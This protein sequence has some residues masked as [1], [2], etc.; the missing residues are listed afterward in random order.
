MV[1][2]Y[3]DIEVARFGHRSIDAFADYFLNF[4]DLLSVVKVL[5]SDIFGK[6]IGPILQGDVMHGWNEEAG[7][8]SGDLQVLAR[9]LFLFVQPSNDRSVDVLISNRCQNFVSDLDLWHF[10]GQFLSVLKDNYFGRS[11]E[12]AGGFRYTS[13][14][15]PSCAES[16]RWLACAGRN[17][18]YCECCWIYTYK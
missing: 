13:I 14:L 2:A 9:W 11:G 6:S 12:A 4:H 8:L 10:L 15:L 5:I 17:W 1:L 18:I 7:W 16:S 3:F